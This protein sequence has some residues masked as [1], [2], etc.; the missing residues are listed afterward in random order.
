M[1]ILVLLFWFVG[2][3]ILVSLLWRLIK[4][5]DQHYLY[6]TLKGEFYRMVK[7]WRLMLYI[8]CPLSTAVLLYLV[9]DYVVGSDLSTGQQAWLIFSSLLTIVGFGFSHLSLPVIER[10][11]VVIIRRKKQQD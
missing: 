11:D 6:Y 3:L 4:L 2:W 5:N 10:T 9:Y 8:L 7:R 1:G